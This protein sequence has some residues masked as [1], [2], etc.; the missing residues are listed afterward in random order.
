MFTTLSLKDEEVISKGDENVFLLYVVSHIFLGAMWKRLG[1][2]RFFF[3]DGISAVQAD[4]GLDSIVIPFIIGQLTDLGYV[5]NGITGS[6]KDG[7]KGP[8]SPLPYSLITTKGITTMS[9]WAY[10]GQDLAFDLITE[11]R[12]RWGHGPSLDGMGK[13]S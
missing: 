12:H 13:V 8:L 4:L 9:I 6:R 7:K 11:W 3:P 2:G 5:K 10:M 1:L